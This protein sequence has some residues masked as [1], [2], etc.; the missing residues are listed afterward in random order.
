M[1][2]LTEVQ[3][4]L[5]G[6]IVSQWF[7]R[8]TAAER[9]KHRFNTIARLCRQ[10]FGSSAK[11]MWED[12]FRKEFYPGLSQPQF[13]INLNKAFELVAVIGPNLFWQNPERKVQSYQTPDQITIAQIMGIQDE[14]VLQAIQQQQ[15]MDRAT[16]EIRNGLATVVLD[17]TQNEQP[18]LLK[19]ELAE[20]IQELLLTGLGLSWTESYFHP[21]TGEF[22]TKNVHR[23]VDDLSIDPD[24]KRPDWQDAR[25]ISLKHYEP[26]WMVERKFGYPPG[27]L[28]GR[29]TR[30]SAE[31]MAVRETSDERDRYCDMIEWEEVWS[32]GGIGARVGGVD[33]QKSQFLDQ[34]VGD[35][36]YLCLSKNVPHPLNIPP[37]MLAEG[38]VELVK[39]AVRWRTSGFGAVHEVW[40][41]NR[42]PCS[43]V[44]SYTVPGSPWPLAPMAAGLGYLIAMNVIM[45]AKLG[46]AWERRR[47]IIG[48]ATDMRDALM[49]ALKS[50]ESP[51]IVPISHAVGRPINELI[52]RLDRGASQDDLLNWME[53]LGSEFAK[54]TGLMD[55]HYGLSQTQSRI[56]S[57]IDAKNRAASVRPEKMRADIVDW[58][59]HFSTSELWLACQYMTGQQLQPL[60]GPFG[61]QAWDAMVRT[62]P[63]EELMREMTCFIDAKDLQRPDNAR[64]LDGLNAIS[65]PF[66]QTATLYGQQTGDPGPLN[67]FMQA[68][69][70]AM[71]LRAMEGVQFGSWMPQPDPQAQQMQQM[72]TQLQM[73]KLEADAAETQAKT[74]GRLTDTQFKMRGVTPAMLTKIQ[75]DQMKFN[76]QMDQ[77]RMDHLQELLQNEELFQQTLAQIKQ[78]N[79]ASPK[80]MSS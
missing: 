21:G 78:K 31:H 17:Y 57:D 15:Q 11:A 66:L 45:V 51:A 27:Y 65:Q 35:N 8:I 1:D 16:K 18:G 34:V 39:E 47:D 60:L 72:M 33:A 28:T 22:L 20:G 24:S 70:R 41:D 79:A 6:P 12:D 61:A 3:S 36:V 10:F 74:V 37:A 52:D 58:V 50:D 19:K 13:Q 71:D 80:G 38:S 25:W 75:Q 26:V 43:P 14:K 77:N 73:K 68:W 30:V 48:V 76:L 46:Q 44:S 9:S 29:G 7:S 54:A 53:Y 55:I 63:F 67:A 56:S 59:K 4:H 64:D 5:L 42:W 2:T 32:R 69:F 49:A 23:S 40:K 62:L